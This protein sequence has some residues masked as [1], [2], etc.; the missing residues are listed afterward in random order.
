MSELLEIVKAFLWKAYFLIINTSFEVYN[1]FQTREIVAKPRDHLLLLSA[2]KLVEKLKAKEVTSTQI[3]KAYIKRIEEVNKTINAAVCKNYE[4]A[5]EAAGKCDEQ[6]E[7]VDANSEE[8]EK[9]YTECPLFGVPFTVKDSIEYK[10]LNVTCGITARKGLISTETAPVLQ[11]VTNAGAIL[12]ALTNV[13]EIC[14][15]VESSNKVYG[16]SRNAY[17]S[18]RGVG[19]SSGGEGAL[20]S[21]AG[22]VIGVG[23]DIGGSIRIPSLFNG[24]FGLKTTQDLVDAHLHIPIGID[25]GG[26][27][28]EL[29]VIGPLCRYA[30][31]L[32]LMLKAMAPKV[33]GPMKVDAPMNLEG[34]RAYYIT[35]IDGNDLQPVDWEIK[36]GVF[37]VVRHLEMD[38]GMR[39]EKVHFAEMAETFNMWLAAMDARGSGH[40]T[41][42]EYATNCEYSLNLYTEL[43]KTMVGMS[44][45]TTAAVGAG[46]AEAN[47]PFDFEGRD[48]L[49]ER[50]RALR[51][52]VHELLANNSVLVFPGWNTP[53]PYHNQLL[54][55]P[56]HLCY[57]I[58]WNIMSTPVVVCP[59]GLNRDGVPIGC[60]IVGAPNS[61]RLLISVAQELE[62]KFGGWTPPGMH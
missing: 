58:I 49:I 41:F 33:Y 6:L 53:A 13:P 10:G 44:D 12:L 32:P 48:K 7:K 56:T 34:L 47:P 30:V 27:R 11:N 23:S 8:M 1:Y 25:L 59:L 20:L 46:I 52:E 31:D 15:W 19:G 50:L 37:D 29:A 57:T 35:H 26:L 5:L 18:R 43:L 61:E 36:K 17:D 16:R 24:V 9:I 2:Q 62:R 42:A 40:P 60:Q 4:N 54:F 38:V 14:M 28:R 3:V 21:A 45:H 22:S 51:K 39:S 55:T